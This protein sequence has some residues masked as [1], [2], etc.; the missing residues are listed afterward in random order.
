[1]RAVADTAMQG[2]LEQARKTLRSIRGYSDAQVDDELRAIV[3]NENDE[4]NLAGEAKFWELFH[5]SSWRVA[6]TIRNLM[7]T[8]NLA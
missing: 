3:K 6:D 4:R 8:S 1:M 7:L 5:V 2:R